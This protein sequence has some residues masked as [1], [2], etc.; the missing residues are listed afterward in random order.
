MPPQ[1]FAPHAT[2]SFASHAT[3]SFAS[4]ATTSFASHAT[5]SFSSHTITIL[6]PHS[7]AI[8]ILYLPYQEIR[9]QLNGEDRE[10]YFMQNMSLGGHKVFNGKKKNK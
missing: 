2:T 6:G 8:T 7:N 3:T 4:H 10:K 5:S 1:S 9:S